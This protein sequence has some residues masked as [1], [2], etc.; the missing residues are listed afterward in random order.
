LAA[1]NY[2]FKFVNGV[3]TVGQLS[4]TSIAPNS[5]DIGSSATTI[6]LTG[7][8]FESS[9]TAQ[10][11]AKAVSTTFVNNT[12]LK[13]VIPATDLVNPATLEISVVDSKTSVTT[14]SLPFT[15]VI[16]PV[17]ISFSGPPSGQ[18]DEQSSLTFQLINP[19]PAPL[20][21]TLSLVF[22]PNPKA[23]VVD[24]TVQFAT[25]GT[26][27]TFTIP[28][29]STA[30]PDIAL[31]TG[32]TAGTITVSLGLTTDGVDVTPTGLQP[33]VIDIAEAVPTLSS[34]VLTQNGDTINVVIEGFS[35]TREASTATF[36]FT[37][38]GTITNPTVPVA[39]TPLFTT[40]YANTA[41]DAY[42]TAFSYQQSF[43]L[44]GPTLTITGVSVTLANTVGTSPAE[45]SQ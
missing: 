22:T 38:D 30:T 24:P 21:V 44:N 23:G 11:N 32:T 35:N 36:S 5:A 25:G 45:A 43:T 13:A 15:V 6:T 33:V 41:S 29:N 7:V 8:G 3:L 27:Y 31:Q 16:P 20:V 4:L 42:G 28:A 9:C 1:T 10:V 39:A 37:A 14:S 2:T 17:N 12:T 40:W 34:V 26:T 19:Y 18:S